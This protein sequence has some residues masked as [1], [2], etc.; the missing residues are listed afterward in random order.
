MNE[1]CDDGGEP[2]D[3]NM[4]VTKV[5]DTYQGQLAKEVIGYSDNCSK[6]CAALNET[7]KVYPHKC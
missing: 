2:E 7:L 6:L 5:L 1:L 4:S 3:L